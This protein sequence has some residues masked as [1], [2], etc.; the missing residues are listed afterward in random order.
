MGIDVLEVDGRTVV[1]ELLLRLPVDVGPQE[2]EDA[3]RLAGAVDVLSSAAE[4][5]TEDAAVR[6]FRLV[7]EVLTA[8][9]DPDAPGRALARCAY[10]DVG[11]FVEVGEASRFPLGARALETGVPATGRAGPDTAPFAVPGGWV[12]WVAPQVTE[13][14]RLTVVARRLN[15]RFSAT[16]AGRLRAFATLLEV[17]QRLPV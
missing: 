8:P 5:S 1:D 16:E 15:V 9:A 13:P 7:W 3:L 12:L 17:T 4:R 14:T 6:A 2:V 11:A 10:A